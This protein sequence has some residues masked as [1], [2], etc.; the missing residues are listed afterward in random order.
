MTVQEYIDSLYKQANDLHNEW[1]ESLI[2]HT[3]S[4]DELEEISS[5]AC[6]LE[7]KAL[8]LQLNAD[9]NS[10]Y[11]VGFFKEKYKK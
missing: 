4:E 6:E 2:H 10:E 3:K 5:K 11:K 7:S 9:L 1:F 8:K